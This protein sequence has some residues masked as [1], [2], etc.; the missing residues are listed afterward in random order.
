MQLNSRPKLA[1]EKIRQGTDLFLSLIRNKNFLVKFIQCM[2]SEISFTMKDRTEVASLL[3]VICQ[4]R[5][6]YA[7]DILKRLLSLLIHRSIGKSHPKLL[8][9]RTESVAEKLLTNWLT[10]CL[11]QHIQESVGK[12]L[13]TLFRAVKSQIEKGPVDAITGESRYALSEDKLLRHQVDYRVN[14]SVTGVAV[15]TL[16]MLIVT[17]CLTLSICLRL[18]LSVSVCVLFVCCLCVPICL[19]DTKLPYLVNKVSRRGEHAVISK[20]S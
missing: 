3:M 20:G 19:V 8:L 15:V 5:M 4:D 13:Y 14:C 1:D 18:S 2:E 16:C 10:F 17:V 7:T 6:D 12:P 9:R 11:Q